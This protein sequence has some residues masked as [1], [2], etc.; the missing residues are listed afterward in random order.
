[1]CASSPAAITTTLDCRPSESP[2]IQG[3]WHGLSAIIDSKSTR[4]VR[5]DARNAHH[6]RHRRGLG[7]VNC[8]RPKINA[9]G[10][11]WPVRAHGAFGR[12]V[13]G[14]HWSAAGTGFQLA[15]RIQSRAGRPR[16]GGLVQLNRSFA[17]AKPQCEPTRTE[18]S[19]SHRLE[20]ILPSPRTLVACRGQAGCLGLSSSLPT[21][22]E[23]P[24]RAASATGSR[25]GCGGS[26]SCRRPC[27]RRHRRCRT[28]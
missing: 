5:H 28:G 7:G 15:P 21:G 22:S 3:F 4:G 26:A 10:H 16:S 27:D 8:A 20:G 13:Q 24:Q 12:P 14:V 11:R 1:M 9:A 2:S 18:G 23:A 19:R 25:C 17:P 6:H